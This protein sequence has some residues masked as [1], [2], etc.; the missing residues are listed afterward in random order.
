[1]FTLGATFLK[2]CRVL[3]LTLPHVDPSLYISRFAVAL[4]FGDYTQRVAQDAVRIAQ[5]MNRDWI[6]SG[7]RPAGICGA[8]LLI[9]ARMNGFRRTTQEMIYVVKVADITIQ[10]RLQEFSRTESAQLSVRDFRTI[11]LEKHADPPSFQKN[12][13]A[14]NDEADAVDEHGHKKRRKG[15][16]I[17]IR[18]AKR[19]SVD[20]TASQ[21][22]KGKQR[23]MEEIEEEEEEEEED[24][25]NEE[26]DEEE[27]D[28]PLKVSDE[29]V[30]GPFEGDQK[31]V[32]EQD[33]GVPGA[34]PKIVSEEAIEND[35]L[36]QQIEESLNEEIKHVADVDTSLTAEAN[37][38]EKDLD[39]TQVNTQDTE[40]ELTL[41]EDE[42]G[43]TLVAETEHPDIIPIKNNPRYDKLSL[44]EKLAISA[45][46][47]AKIAR[48]EEELLNPGL[49]EDALEIANDMESWMGDESIMK[50]ALDIGTFRSI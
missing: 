21:K 50:A 6:T 29:E 20:L 49:Q 13:K 18:E 26:S 24:E 31:D 25:L 11:W 12:R 27:E 23:A 37:I 15:S 44:E 19:R 43:S 40:M 46:A 42:L 14:A 47:K 1:M 30:N 4:D 35:L 39:A 22:R 2:L 41:V 3:N 5:R 34:S 10:K 16:I 38:K 32:S 9:A 28:D 8:C 48:E 45:Y 7:R 36:T 17:D 33:N